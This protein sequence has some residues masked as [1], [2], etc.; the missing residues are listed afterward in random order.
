MPLLGR[1]GHKSAFLQRFQHALSLRGRALESIGDAFDIVAIVHHPHPLQRMS[2]AEKWEA[3][4]HFVGVEF[5]LGHKTTLPRRS[6]SLP[7]T[8]CDNQ[9]EW[10]PSG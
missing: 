8:S 4:H 7:V 1:F 2:D 3:R 10:R 6:H 9:R 5:R